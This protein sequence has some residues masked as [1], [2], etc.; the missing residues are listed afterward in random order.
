[1]P[2]NRKCFAILA[3]GIYDSLIEVSVG[4]LENDSA[5]LTLFG[6][7]LV[8][9]FIIFNVKLWK[10]GIKKINEHAIKDRALDKQT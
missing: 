5:L 2:A 1:M 7:A 4:F 8:I 6:F 10:Y 3:H 9:V